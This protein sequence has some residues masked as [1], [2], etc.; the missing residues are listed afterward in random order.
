MNDHSRANRYHLAAV[1]EILWDVFP[2]GPRFGGAPA[3]FA[4]T[5]V[6]LGQQ[7]TSVSM[8]SAVGNDSLGTEALRELEQHGVD[9]SMVART[10]HD[11]GQV[12]V[13][14]DAT[15]SAS[16][17]FANDAAWDHLVWSDQ[18]A[19]L[20]GRV[21]AACFG[22]LGQRSTTSRAVIQDFMRHVSS[23]QSADPGRERT[24]AVRFG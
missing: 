3:N 18:L 20:A 11:T 16:Y 17:R 1:G 4:C 9:A 23:Y 14:L 7:T 19:Q 12:F 24:N 10:A 2:S 5:A 21:D 15:G 22:T 8:V 13:E 6:A